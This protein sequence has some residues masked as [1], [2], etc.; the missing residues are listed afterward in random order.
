MERPVTVWVI[1]RSAYLLADDSFL[2]QHRGRRLTPSEIEQIVEPTPASAE[3]RIDAAER[4]CTA[5]RLQDLDP[6]DPRD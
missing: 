3:Q 2:A 6:I 5:E 4:R 1:G